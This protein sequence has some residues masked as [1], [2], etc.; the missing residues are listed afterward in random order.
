[1]YI[2]P[3]NLSSFGLLYGFRS[4]LHLWADSSRFRTFSMSEK[5]PKNNMNVC[6]AAEPG[7]LQNV[8][9]SDMVLLKI[10]N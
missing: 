9:A 7:I 6:V 1:M 4:S 3:F 8:M 2:T 5:L 10:F